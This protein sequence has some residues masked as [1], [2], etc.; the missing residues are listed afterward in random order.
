[1]QHIGQL[2]P[3]VLN[4]KQQG[5]ALMQKDI[6]LMQMGRDHMLKVVK[7]KEIFKEELQMEVDHMLKDIAPMLKV[8]GL[9]Q[10]VHRHL[11]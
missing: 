2:T 7:Q 10:K 3:K 9:M 1:M 4:L 11:Q 5:T 6:F 8:N